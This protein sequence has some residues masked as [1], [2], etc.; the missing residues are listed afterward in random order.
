MAHLCRILVFTMLLVGVAIYGE[1]AAAATA[2]EIDAEVD[3]A[4]AKLF[5]EVPA[6]KKIADDA[7]GVLVF[8]SIIKGGFGLGGEYGEGALRRGGS[9]TNYYNIAS[10]SF[11]FQIGA[12]GYSNVLMFMTEEAIRA[13]NNVK[14]FELGADASIA[15]A[16][17]GAGGEIS[18]NTVQSPVIA[19][20]FGQKGLMGGISIEGSKITKLDK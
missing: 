5:A 1:R 20:V 19:F 12:Q 14:G 15:V 11:G 10:V 7:V 6:A 2:A 16:D 8:P 17:I 3:A 18:S 9:T 13:L 4:L